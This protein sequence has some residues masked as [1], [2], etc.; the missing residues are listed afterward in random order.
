MIRRP[1]RS[2]L[3]PYTTLFRSQQRHSGS[4]FPHRAPNRYH[5]A[6]M[7][8]GALLEVCVTSVESAVAAARGGA[9]RVE[10][11]SDLL[12]GGVTPSG[13]LIARV[14]ERIRVRLQVIIRP[15]GGAF[16]YS[17]AE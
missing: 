10:L 12:E 11:V 6:V 2:T 1:P 15:R 5:R 9:A 7:T 4:I 8:G 16:R 3:F 17:G 13:G 14:R